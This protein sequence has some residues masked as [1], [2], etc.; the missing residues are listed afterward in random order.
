MAPLLSRG[1]LDLPNSVAR[2]MRVPLV[3]V[4]V[5]TELC[6]GSGLPT[7][8]A[9]GLKNSE[10]RLWDCLCLCPLNRESLCLCISSRNNPRHLWS[11]Y[12][13]T[14]SNESKPSLNKQ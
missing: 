7:S 12:L 9:L 2:S 13:M 1:R 5:G 6:G 4:W 3:R 11:W 8:V 14:L 10:M